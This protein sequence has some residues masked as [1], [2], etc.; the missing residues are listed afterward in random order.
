MVG[1]GAGSPAI[2]RVHHAVV[3][4]TNDLAKSL[5]ANGLKRP[6]LVS[7]DEQT[8]GR[9]RH[10][11]AW[12]SPVGGAWMTLV[13]PGVA[14][15]G[16]VLATAPLVAGLALADAIDAVLTDA[17]A[18]HDPAAVRIK[19]PNDVLLDGKKTG[20]VLCE[21][22]VR[23][24][25]GLSAPLIVGVGVNVNN[26]PAELGRALGASPRVPATSLAAFAD[27]VLEPSALID[28]FAGRAVSL[29]GRLTA[30]GFTPE[31]RRAV[32]S[33]MA[34]RDGAPVRIGE[35]GVGVVAGLDAEGRLVVRGD[36]GSERSYASGE[37]RLGGPADV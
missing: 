7:A 27:R 1:P 25:S 9:G 23:P 32:E 12:A 5:A 13:W 35:V 26:D 22:E 10:G 8:D 34:Y 14:G 6:L 37:V 3:G 24:S 4:S 16:D 29:L 31:L 20:G 17:G 21:R 33:R 36:D 11:R 19:W 28:A 18:G 2:D 15:A 30:S